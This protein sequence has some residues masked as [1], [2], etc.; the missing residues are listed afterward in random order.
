LVL[1]RPLVLTSSPWSRAHARISSGAGA[2]G[3]VVGWALGRA[4][5]DRRVPPIRRP[6]VVLQHRTQLPGVLIAQV[7]FVG[8]VR[9]DHDRKVLRLVPEAAR[10]S[11]QG[12]DALDLFPNRLPTQART[13][14]DD[15]AA[16]T[17]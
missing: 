10:G 11:R 9:Q 16:H 15:I 5:V 4:L 17:A 7:D 12:H 1:I 2:L 3:V 14:V 13:Q 6:A 8:A